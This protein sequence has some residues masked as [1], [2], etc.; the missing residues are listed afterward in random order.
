MPAGAKQHDASGALLFA[1]YYFQAWDW[2][3]ATNDPYLLRQVSAPSCKYCQETIG[4]ITSITAAGG[5]LLGGRISTEGLSLSS[6]T[7]T[8]A[9]HVVIVTSSQDAGVIQE[10]GHADQSVAPQQSSYQFAAYM[11]WSATG[12]RVV[13]IFKVAG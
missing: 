13:G 7:A 4:A 1:G 11:N 2:S 12:W 10:P 9:E 5:R 3:M 8:P 6:G